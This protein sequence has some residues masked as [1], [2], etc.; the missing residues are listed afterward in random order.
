MPP[1]RAYA[2]NA[3]ARNANAAPPVPNQ[4]VSNAEFR[5]AIQMLAQ[6]VANQNNQR[7][8][9]PVNANGRSA[10]ARVRDFVRMNPPEFLGSQTSED[11]QNFL[12]EIKKIFE[13]M[14]VT[15]NDRVE[16]AYKLKY[17]FLHLNI[18]I[19]HHDVGLIPY[20]SWITKI[21]NNL[22]VSIAHF[23]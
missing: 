13:V 17:I 15:G 7:V 12:D 20:F 18:F 22:E 8:Q 1:R 6:S 23:S 5:N 2:R 19:C 9:A 21:L 10:A 4:E 11:P 14:Q 16:L 3:N